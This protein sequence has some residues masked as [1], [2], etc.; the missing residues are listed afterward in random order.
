MRRYP[1]RAPSARGGSHRPRFGSLFPV[2]GFRP[3]L[4]PSAWGCFVWLRVGV[5]L[6][7]R[8]PS[9]PGLRWRRGGFAR[10]RFGFFS[11]CAPSA[12]VTVRAGL[13]LAPG[14]FS[15]W[16]SPRRSGD[17]ARIRCVPR[18]SVPKP[19]IRASAPHAPVFRGS[20]NTI[21]MQGFARAGLL[22]LRVCS[23]KRFRSPPFVFAADFCAS[24]LRFCDG[25]AAQAGCVFAMGSPHKRDGVVRCAFQ[26]L[27][28]GTRFARLPD[29][30]LRSSSRRVSRESVRRR[31]RFPP[32]RR[33]SGQCA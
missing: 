19:C 7:R 13:S 11:R 20:E 24:G 26:K 31:R 5:P 16:E 32:L 29:A 33:L 30:P 25:I 9:A 6:L 2:R 28:S 1:P 18:V 23:G 17:V 22:A 21:D 15:L 8:A 27:A 14:R 10:L 3:G 4:S 12:P